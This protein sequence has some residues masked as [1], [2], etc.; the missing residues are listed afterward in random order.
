MGSFG[1]LSCRG[2]CAAWSSVAGSGGG[3][4][5]IGKL[6]RVAPFHLV[7]SSLVEVES[8]IDQESL[9]QESRSGW[10]ISS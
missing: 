10:K 8:A 2:S 4:D 5:A 7:D 1:C 3:S 6:N 9:I